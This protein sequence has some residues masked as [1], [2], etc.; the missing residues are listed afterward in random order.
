MTREHILSE[1]RRTAATNRGVPLGVQRFFTETGIREA[2]WHGKLWARWGDALK[3]A[4]FQPNKFNSPLDRKDLLNNLARL[5]RELGRFPV[6]GEMQMKARSEPGFPSHNTFRRIGGKQVLAAELEKHCRNRGENDI[7]DL[8][9]VAAQA[10]DAE[11]AGVT[12]DTAAGKRGYVYLIKGGHYY[13]IGK[14]NALGRRERELAIQLPEPTKLVHSITTDDPE[15]IE[16]YWHRRFKDRRKN[17][18]WFELTPQDVAA[19][20]RRSFM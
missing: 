15:G 5:V 6:K 19:F 1:I 4:G 2:D 17:G 9:A 10:D 14:T 16:S 7:A 11:D 13:K 20:K 18:E 3:E 12:E 8:C